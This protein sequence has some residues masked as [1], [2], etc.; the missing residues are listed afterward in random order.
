MSICS[1]VSLRVGV[2]GIVWF[3]RATSGSHLTRHVLFKK[4]SPSSYP[5]QSAQATNADLYIAYALRTGCYRTNLVYVPEESPDF[6]FLQTRDVD[7]LRK[8]SVEVKC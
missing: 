3:Y 6:P 5:A 8:L 4:S 7:V 1:R 2:S